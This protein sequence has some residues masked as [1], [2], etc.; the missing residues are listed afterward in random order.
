MQEN[1][2]EPAKKRK[3]KQ[4]FK[5]PLPILWTSFSYATKK[6]CKQLETAHHLGITWWASGGANVPLWW[7]PGLV[8]LGNRNFCY[9]TKLR[10]SVRIRASKLRRSLLDVALIN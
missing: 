1:K 6:K 2:K 5:T 4:C 9:F 3:E 10:K 8:R 7:F